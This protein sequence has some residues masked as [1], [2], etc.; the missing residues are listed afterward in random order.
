MTLAEVRDYLKTVAE[1]KNYYIGRRDGKRDKSLG[2]YPLRRPGYPVAIGGKDA[3]LCGMKAVSLLLHWTANA[4]ET[5]RA[6][7]KL[8]DR[9]LNERDA[10]IGGRKVYHFRPLVPEPV[11]VGTEGDVFER[12]LEF[13][14][15]FERK[16]SDA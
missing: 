2:V 16:D 15:Y 6:A 13:E 14:I 1:A 8:Y 3:T 9:L 12:V 11:D 7:Q 10:V 4:D 5:E